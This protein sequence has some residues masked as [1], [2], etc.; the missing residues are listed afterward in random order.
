MLCAASAADSKILALCEFD[1]VKLSF[2]GDAVKQA[3]CLLRPVKKFAHMGPELAAL[4]APL[5]A[6]VGTATTVTKAKL[7]AHLASETITERDAGGSLDDPLS[8]GSEGAAGAPP[9]RYFV[10]HDTSS[11]NCSSAVSGGCKALGEFPA[12]LN[13]AANRM[14]RLA[15]WASI[16]SPAHIFVNRVGKA[17]LIHDFKTASR[18]TKMEK[19]CQC[20]FQEPRAVP[21][22][23]TG[24][25]AH[26]RSGHSQTRQNRQ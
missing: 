7:R 18:A 14:N 1:T 22:C 26:W 25:A 3:R 15:T 12:D 4:P 5:D 9:A 11:P 10:I 2:A 13:D 24:A 19:G 16:G 21:A 20:R 23:G 8:T 6:L 17:V